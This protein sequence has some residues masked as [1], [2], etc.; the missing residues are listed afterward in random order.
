M[1]ATSAQFGAVPASNAASDAEF[2]GVID[3]ETEV[4]IFV[5][6]KNKTRAGGTLFKYLSLTLFNL[7]NVVYLTVLI[8]T[9]ISITVCA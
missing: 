3:I 5:V 8:D 7:G 9:T 6:D 1:S 4:E 2:A